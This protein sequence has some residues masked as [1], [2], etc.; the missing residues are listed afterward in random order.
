MRTQDKDSIS[1]N[2]SGYHSDTATGVG[3]SDGSSTVD[4]VT[5]TQQVD[6]GIAGSCQE[7]VIKGDNKY[8]LPNGKQSP[9]GGYA[10]PTI[11]EDLSGV[12]WMSYSWP[13]L[14]FSNKKPVPS[15][16]IHLAKSTDSGTTWNFVTKLFTATP[17]ANP[18]NPSQSG[19]LNYEVINMLPVTSNEQTVWYGVTLNYFVPEQG[20]MAARPSNSFHIRVYQADNATKLATAPHAVLG[21]GATAKE[22]NVNQYLIPDDIGILDRKS[23]FW[24][25]PSLYFENGTLYLTMVSFH[26]RNRSDI[27]RD[28]VHVFATHPNGLPNSWKWE[29]KG[30]LAGRAEALFLNSERLTQVDIARGKQGELLLVASPDDWNKQMG[31]YNHKGCVVFEIESLEKPSLKKDSFDNPIIHTEIK[32][33]QA[34]ELGSAA[35]SYNP[36]ST[37]GILF[38][39]RIKNQ[40]ELT[41]SLWQTYVHP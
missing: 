8:T 25:E 26:L 22:W 40:K 10:D 13:H 7:V 39:R 41:A 5:K 28:A 17:M 14:K 38:T 12:L 31:D 11:R 19:Y 36:S 6:C 4:V 29:Y 15:V 16:D 27:T 34:N 3:D 1:S 37:T 2:V 30:K 23:F 9:F 21:G 35:C 33:S 32:D 24:N 18:T 20:G